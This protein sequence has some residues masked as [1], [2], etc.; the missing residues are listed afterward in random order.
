MAMHLLGAARLVSPSS[1]SSNSRTSSRI[2]DNNGGCFSGKG[3][4]SGRVIAISRLTRKRI[5]SHLVVRVR[6]TNAPLSGASEGCG[7][8]LHVAATVAA[9]AACLFVGDVG[10]AD[11][12]TSQDI[13]DAF[14]KVQGVTQEATGYIG[15]A[16]VTMK[17][18]FEKIF[19]AIRPAVD[20][21]VPYVQKA[22]DAVIK[23]TAPVASDVARQAD[24]ALQSVGVDTK[25]VIEV[26]KTAVTIAEEAAENTTKVFESASPVAVSTLESLLASDPFILA[27]GAGGLLLLYL[28]APSIGSS[29]AYAARGYKGNLTAAQ[30]LDLLSKEDYTLVDVRTEKEKAKS[31]VPSLP[32]S[33]KNK[34]LSI[35]LE[36]L[37][38][39]LKGQLRNARKVEA[40]IAA[41]KISSLKKLN[42]GSKIVILDGYG[43]VGKFVAK[44]LTDL[45]FKNTWMIVDGFDGGR[46]WVQSKLGTETY[47]N[48][49]IAEILSPSRIILAAPSTKKLFSNTS[50]DLIDSTPRR[51][52][53]LPSGSSD[54]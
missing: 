25:P 34:F 15:T 29:I 6:A 10:S 38:S 2:S 14:S 48:S 53:L 51:S 8:R 19:T 37:P 47:N 20:V 50:S 22:T 52:R 16:Y 39:K 40:E 41:I 21:A 45:G 17:E 24:N 9:A 35:P 33:V 5:A 13:A 36:E 32:K 11:A 46:G 31:G 42:R 23:I 44:S 18:F 1:S 43:D 12:L 27:G 54:E 3:S 7:R 4:G 30:A 28:F 26:A 49:S